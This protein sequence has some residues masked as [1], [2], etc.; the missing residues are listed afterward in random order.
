MARAIKRQE[1]YNFFGEKK[2]TKVFPVLFGLAILLAACGPLTLPTMSPE[3]VQGTAM[4][5]ALTNVAA[6]QSALPTNTP[7]PPT[8]TPTPT[9]EPTIPPTFT[10]VPESVNCTKS[11][12]VGEAGPLKNVRV[13]NENKGEVN[14]SLNLYQPN[15][16]GQCGAVSYTVKGKTNISIKIPTGSWSAYSWVLD[17]PSNGSV[18]FSIGPSQSTALLRLVIKKDKIVWVGP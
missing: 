9:L 12:N 13:E 5:E 17:P 11:L 14:L 3:D 7:L 6:T 18:N 2:L 1:P 4:A 8:E 16:F 10:A 15:S